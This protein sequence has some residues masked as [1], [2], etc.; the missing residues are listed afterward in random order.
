VS[1]AELLAAIEFGHDCCKKIAA[2][3]RALMKKC[4]WAKKEYVAP[5]VKRRCMTRDRGLGSSGRRTDEHEKYEKLDSY[6]KV[7]AAKKKALG[8]YRKSSR[9]RAR[10]CS[11]R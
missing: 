3:I 5:A 10:S 7:D 4:G 1:E 11:T 9:P 2:G 6:S 8:S